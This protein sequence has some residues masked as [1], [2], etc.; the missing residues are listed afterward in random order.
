MSTFA[1]LRLRQPPTRKKVIE[2]AV[3]GPVG[4]WFARRRWA[5]FTLPLPF[6]VVIFYWN[7]PAPNPYTRVHEFVH[8]E[9]DQATPFF[10]VFWIQYLAELARHGYRRNAYERA[11]F[12]VEHDAFANGLPE[13][14]REDGAQV[15]GRRF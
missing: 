3:A 6:V 14:A 13:W 11:A 2:L 15:R 7:T 4:R 12:A 8:V 5:A 9:Q 1:R 10:L